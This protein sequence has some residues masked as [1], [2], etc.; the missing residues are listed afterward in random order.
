MAL[1]EIASLWIGKRLSF[2]ELLCFK[3]FVDQGHKLTLYTYE[4]L[5]NPPDFCEIA[6]AREPVLAIP[7]FR[8]SEPLSTAAP[9]GRA[10]VVRAVE[11][12]DGAAPRVGPA[13]E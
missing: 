2:L 6:D 11:E 4:P 5:E 13:G 3:S 12:A 10:P 8:R 9:E 7:A 1:P